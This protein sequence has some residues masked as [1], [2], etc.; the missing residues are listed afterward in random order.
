M[1]RLDA[2]YFLKFPHIIKSLIQLQHMNR[3]IDCNDLLQSEQN[4]ERIE[5]LHMEINVPPRYKSSL[6]LYYPKLE[7]LVVFNRSSNVINIG[8][9]CFV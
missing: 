6:F 2:K 3:R 5:I 8:I 9:N 4:R 1:F 7:G